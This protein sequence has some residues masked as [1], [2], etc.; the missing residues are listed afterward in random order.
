MS[1]QSEKQKGQVS[2]RYIMNQGAGSGLEKLVF[3]DKLSLKVIFQ[4]LVV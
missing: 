1:K 4:D 2:T 3:G